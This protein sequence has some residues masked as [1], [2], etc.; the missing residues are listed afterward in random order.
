MLVTQLACDICGN[1]I[2]QGKNVRVSINATPRPSKSC[3]AADV[4]S[5]YCFRAY[6]YR[7]IKEYVDDGNVFSNMEE[8]Q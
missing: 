7:F 3:A 1:V 5:R 8:E 6:V 2:D 4:C